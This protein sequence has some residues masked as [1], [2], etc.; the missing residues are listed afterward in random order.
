MLPFPPPQGPGNSGRKAPEGGVANVLEDTTFPMCMAFYKHCQHLTGKC[1]PEF[2]A[3]LKSGH[4]E[5]GQ[6]HLMEMGVGCSV[7]VS[8][9]PGV[10]GPLKAEEHS[11]GSY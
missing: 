4:K 7:L 10:L 1:H 6:G 5:G 11:S 8:N 3:I 2:C 9:G